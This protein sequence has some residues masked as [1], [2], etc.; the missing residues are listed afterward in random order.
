MIKKTLLNSLGKHYTI[1]LLERDWV[2]NIL[3]DI[4]PKQIAGMVYERAVP[5]WIIDID[6][7]CSSGE[8]VSAIRTAGSYSIGTHFINVYTEQFN[9]WDVDEV[10]GDAQEELLGVDPDDDWGFRQMKFENSSDHK[11]WCVSYLSDWIEQELKGK[12]FKE[13]LDRIYE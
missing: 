8:L 1:E 11:E 6:L 9:G 10:L 7:D 3:K 13:E 2:F 12:D 4:D 5:G